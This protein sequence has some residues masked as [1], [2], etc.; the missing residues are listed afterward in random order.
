MM[1]RNRLSIAPLAMVLAIACAPGQS[2]PVPPAGA[3][4]VEAI[5]EDAYLYGLQQVIFYETRYNYTQNE[6]SEVYSGVNRW[7]FV[8]DGQP[9]TPEFRAIVTPNATTLYGTGFLDLQDEPVILYTPEI[10]DRYFSL[11]LMDQYG[12]YFLYAGN[13]FNGTRARRY[14][15]LPSGYDGPI[16][17]DFE[18]TEV[19]QAP[20]R[21][22]F[23]IYRIA[24]FDPTDAEEIAS[25][26]DLQRQ[27]TIT[28]LSEWARNERRPLARKDQSLSAGD[29]PTFP[30]MEQLTTRQV[31]LQT[32][33]D[34]FT[35][36]NLVLN[37]SSLTLMA[38]SEKESAMLARL[39][40][41][42]LGAG[43]GFEW[44]RLDPQTRQALDAGFRT[45]FT[46]VKRSG[47]KEMIDMSG[48]MT[49]RNSGGFE[50]D[51]LSRAVMADF[52]WAG[53]DRNISH[54][55]AFL[56]NDSKGNRLNGKHRYTLTFKLVYLPPVT[57]FWSIPIYDEHG[58]FVPN[59][60][61]RYTINSFM[62]DQGKLHIK[63]GKLR[64][65]I[66]H[67]RPTDPLELQNWLPAPEGEFRFA[68][69]FYGPYLSLI[70]GS[71]EMARV[72]RRID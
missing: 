20:T 67:E 61:D 49:M 60:I 25:I 56:L 34:F 40:T 30:R 45:G 51:W 44:S 13:Q 69:R 23:A 37:D 62:L 22:V 9:I 42:G 31:V 27:A 7:F 2:T 24:I 1:M 52:G 21:S 3:D 14:L 28:P 32:A 50:T 35:L 68:A 72:E 33:E 10:T 17:G 64:I 38:D 47:W 71:H 53:P 11:Q 70:D 16:P 39:A 5:A 65:F 18:T 66:Q 36:L 48:W 57:Q 26:N 55:G 29:Y 43:Q 19:I 54:T 8:N 6:Q 41:V 12:I 4:G 58:Y 46:R 63:H 15:I 59:E